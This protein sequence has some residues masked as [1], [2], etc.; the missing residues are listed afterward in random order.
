[1]VGCSGILVPVGIKVRAS[2]QPNPTPDSNPDPKPKPKRAKAGHKTRL[3]RV[4]TEPG[5]FSIA[6]DDSEVETAPH[7][8]HVNNT[9]KDPSSQMV[10]V[11]VV[12]VVLRCITYS[13]NNVE[14]KRAPRND[15]TTPNVRQGILPTHNPGRLLLYPSAQSG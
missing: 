8:F 13:L 2:T 10:V 9:P 15:H 3:R 1:M 11:V 6:D 4:C 5:N 14:R 12:A 7:N